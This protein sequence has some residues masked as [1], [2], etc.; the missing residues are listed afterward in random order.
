[1][2]FIFFLSQESRNILSTYLPR[3]DGRPSTSYY[4]EGG[5]LYG[6]GLV[7]G[8]YYDEEVEQ[9]LLNQVRR[10]YPSYLADSGQQGAARRWTY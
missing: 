10:C 8:N 9:Y 3:D 2:I 5:A 1:M 7:H 6:M 4:S